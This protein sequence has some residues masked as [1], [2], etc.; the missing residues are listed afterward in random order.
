MI[1]NW[2]GDHFY[3][4]APWNSTGSDWHLNSCL[5]DEGARKRKG[6]F[7]FHRDCATI[8]CVWASV[9]AT[10][11]EMDAGWWASLRGGQENGSL[12]CH[13]CAK[14]TNASFQWVLQEHI[15]ISYFVPLFWE[16]NVSL[17]WRKPRWST[18]ARY[19]LC[20]IDWKADRT[21]GRDGERKGWVSSV[22]KSTPGEYMQC[23]HD[24]QRNE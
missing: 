16:Q 18:L 17:V 21:W 7:W 22:K 6:V 13:I 3:D 5:E 4:T 23:L 20:C 19:Y 15:K 14:S 24:I 9:S 10:G 2:I 1:Y 8:V 12:T 11:R